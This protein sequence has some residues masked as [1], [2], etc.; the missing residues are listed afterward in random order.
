MTRSGGS[1]RRSTMLVGVI[2]GLLTIGV[3]DRS[4]ANEFLARSKMFRFQIKA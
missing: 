3:R 4:W 1:G 2:V